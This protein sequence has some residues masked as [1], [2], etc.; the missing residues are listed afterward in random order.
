MGC[1]F[2]KAFSVS[3]D[4]LH[5]GWS[6]LASLGLFLGMTL[7][8]RKGVWYTLHDSVFVRSALS[9]PSLG[10]LMR[11]YDERGVKKVH[12]RWFIRFEELPLCVRRVTPPGKVRKEVFIALGN[13]K[14]VENENVVEVLLGKAT[15]LCTAKCRNNPVPLELHVENA[16]HVINRVYNAYEKKFLKMDQIEKSL[17]ETQTSTLLIEQCGLLM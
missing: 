4:L 1:T 16:H 14:G 7:T 12:I 17:C 15:V 5:I 8:F 2:S 9:E 10:K 13:I 6:L 3:L 11:L